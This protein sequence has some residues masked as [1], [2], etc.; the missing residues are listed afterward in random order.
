MVAE[1]EYFIPTIWR[2]IVCPSGIR[3]SVC[4]TAK[5]SCSNPT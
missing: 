1:F 5:T 2:D 3:I 4:Y